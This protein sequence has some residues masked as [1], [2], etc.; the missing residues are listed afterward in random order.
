MNKE[1][2]KELQHIL[3]LFD[4]ITHIEIHGQSGE[5]AADVAISEKLLIM[6]VVTYLRFS[7]QMINED[8]KNKQEKQ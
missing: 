7:L 2:V 6:N 1:Q 3:S 4:N 8:F 5:M